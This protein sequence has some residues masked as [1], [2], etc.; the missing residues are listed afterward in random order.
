MHSAVTV[1]GGATLGGNGTVGATTILN[2]GTIAPGNS[3]GTLHINGAFAQSAGSIYQVE[4]DPTSNASDLILVNGAATVDPAANLN[5]VKNP[6][7]DYRPGAHYTVLTA[8]GGV[9]GSYTVPGAGALSQFLA[10]QEAQDANDIYLNVVQTGDPASV[11]TTP[12]Q[13]GV[14]NNLPNGN[15]AT[16]P[17][18]NVRS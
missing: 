16:M 1:Q 11:A 14:A 7:G 13:T 15:R 4:V 3:I 10:L 5:I 8:S 18:L 17:I 9:T 6:A 12:N 2:G